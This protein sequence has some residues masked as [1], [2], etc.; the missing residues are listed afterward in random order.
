MTETNNTKSWRRPHQTATIAGVINLLASVVFMCTY[1][2]T[3]P[4]GPSGGVHLIM[5]QQFITFTFP[6][7]VVGI[8]ASLFSSGYRLALSIFNL[9]VIG[10]WIVADIPTV[11]LKR[12]IGL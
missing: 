1:Y 9:P 6:V 8:I 3:A 10:V 12:A 4:Q 7:L 11:Y 2:S 5:L